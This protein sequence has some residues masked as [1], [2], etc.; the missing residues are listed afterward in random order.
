MIKDFLFIASF[1]KSIK[2]N[3]TKLVDKLFKQKKA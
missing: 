1:Q 2:S 3:R